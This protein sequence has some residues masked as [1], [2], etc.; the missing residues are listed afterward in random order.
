MR[1]LIAI[2]AVALAIPTMS[3][4]ETEQEYAERIAKMVQSGA[5]ATDIG[6]V[7][8]LDFLNSP[9]LK[10]RYQGL[11]IEGSSS[12]YVLD[13]NTGAVKYCTSS[14]CKAVAEK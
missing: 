14:G 1:K 10:R 6:M 13:T 9:I 8:I 7:A 3:F 4:A 2:L 5:T 12:I 11:R